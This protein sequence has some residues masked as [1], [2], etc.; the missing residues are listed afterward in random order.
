MTGNFCSVVVYL[1]SQ[2]KSSEVDHTSKFPMYF[3]LTPYALIILFKKE[4]VIGI[5]INNKP[6]KFFSD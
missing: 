3:Y 2:G 6:L 4:Y 5:T 1:K